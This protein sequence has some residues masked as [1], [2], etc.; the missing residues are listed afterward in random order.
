MKS[1]KRNALKESIG[2][3]FHM[4]FVALLESVAS[5]SVQS[6]IIRVLQNASRAAQ[7][8]FGSLVK[9]GVNVGKRK[10]CLNQ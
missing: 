7:L 8:R 3:T 4:P 10:N 6:D 2:S 5:H 1:R 9:K